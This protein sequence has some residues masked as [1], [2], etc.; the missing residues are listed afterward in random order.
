VGP[1]YLRLGRAGEPKLLDE[2]TEWTLGRATVVREGSDVTL[3]STGG[4]L[5]TALEAADR[6][7]EQGY[8]AGVLSVHTLKPLD[9]EVILGAAEQTGFLAT[10]EE[11]ALS[12]GLGSAVGEVL[13]D[14]DFRRVRCLRFGVPPE[15]AS[16]VGNQDHFRRH[17]GLDADS[18]AARLGRELSGR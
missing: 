9:R 12:G 2:A 17:F 11:H 7:A 14:A 16:I 1:A 3:L 18:I 4:M 13:L 5:G 15:F 6:L 10:I 8:R